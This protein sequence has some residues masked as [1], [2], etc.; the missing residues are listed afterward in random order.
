MA[1]TTVPRLL[2]H[3]SGPIALAVNA[4]RDQ[5]AAERARARDNEEK[6]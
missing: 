4:I 6:K 1:L 5:R 3:Y 2:G